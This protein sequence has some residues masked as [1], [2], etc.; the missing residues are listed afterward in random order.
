LTLAS[1]GIVRVRVRCPADAT[2][3]CQGAVAVEALGGSGKASAY[4]ASASKRRHS[5]NGAFSVKA[6]KSKVIKVRIS[7]NGRRRVLQQRKLKCKVSAVDK[8]G[9]VT[10][11]QTVTVKAPKGTGR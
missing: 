10:A 8:S 5:K 4:R 1:T 6:G 11:S 9:K 7:R 3:G 2:G